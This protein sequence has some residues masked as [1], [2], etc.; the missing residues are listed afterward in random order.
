L[1]QVLATL[2]PEHE[3]FQK[4]YE[5]PHANAKVC[6]EAQILVKNEDDFFGCLPA[7]TG[8][9]KL[10]LELADQ[11]EYK[12]MLK[13]KLLA[14]QAAIMQQLQSLDLQA[15]S[16]NGDTTT[17]STDQ[18]PAQVASRNHLSF[19]ST[20]G[21]QPPQQAPQPKPGMFRFTPKLGS[22]KPAARQSVTVEMASSLATETAANTPQKPRKDSSQDQSMS[23]MD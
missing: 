8:R 21:G 15:D 12:L 13:E 20:A 3:Y 1:L 4:G 9:G 22:K 17:S 5:P 23:G 16:N 18:P 19:G 7:S 10:Y 14:Q 11:G 2:N 6:V